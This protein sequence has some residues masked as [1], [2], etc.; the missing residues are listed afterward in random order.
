MSAALVGA[1]LV[2]IIPRIA[3]LSTR[4][5]VGAAVA[6]GVVGGLPLAGDSLYVA[7]GVMPLVVVTAL[8]AWRGPE[9]GAGR[10]VAFGLG[11]LGATVL[12][13]FVFAAIMRGEGIRG[14]A[15]SYHQFMTFTS[16]SGLITNIGTLL[17]ALPSLTAG[18]FFGRT[19]T[20]RSELEIVS[21]VMLFAAL[22]ALIWSVRRRVA[23]ALPR[24]AGG[25]DVVGERFVHTTFWS[26]ALGV[27]LLVF[28]VASPNPFTTDGRYLLG[29]YVAIAALLPLMLERGLGWKLI[30][31]AC[32]S[33][34][35]FS[36]LYQFNSGVKEI[37]KGYETV[38]IA[39]SVASF[40]QQQ[41]VAVGYAYYWNSIDLTWESD[42]KVNVYPIQRCA[43][44]HRALCTFSEIS[45]SNWD[46][47]HGNVRSMLVLN[48]KAR[49]VR[50][51]EMA[52]G[53]PIARVKI[54]N[55]K[56][57]VYPYDIAT[58]LLPEKGLTL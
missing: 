56:V 4:R 34:F 25:G 38:G 30:V 51:R 19:V 41:H 37:A 21:A 57:L 28:L 42:F 22:L 10:V 36:A 46:E 49:M 54:G 2:W 47:P 11:A 32:V 14:F 24:A 58:K 45:M 1:A 55:L 5:L 27:G 31:T 3:T 44:I 43:H 12:T 52:L 20:T 6:I 35:V 16:P 9:D 39:R 26:T 15:P 13:S 23:N 17:R 33:A 40:A 18:D 7:W 8:A 48:P 29:P 50:K 53:T